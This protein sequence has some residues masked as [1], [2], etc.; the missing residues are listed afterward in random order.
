MI[1]YL[2]IKKIY[3][4]QWKNISIYFDISNSTF[5]VFP[6]YNF[7]FSIYSP[8]S[9]H[10]FPFIFFSFHSFCPRSAQFD[11]CLPG[12]ACHNNCGAG[13]LRWLALAALWVL[14]SQD[15]TG[16][17][18]GLQVKEG[19]MRTDAGRT[20]QMCRKNKSFNVSWFYNAFCQSSQPTYN[21]YLSVK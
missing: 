3:T 8:S 16:H 14:H 11:R 10:F 17:C 21:R 4:L 7:M 6:F 20:E 2:V 12:L 13:C 1:W 19:E 18:L 9:S 5:I 15:R